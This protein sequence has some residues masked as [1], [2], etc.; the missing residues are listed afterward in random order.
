M[1]DRKPLNPSSAGSRRQ[2]KP[3]K[4]RQRVKPVFGA[5]G[6]AR[7]RK[8]AA[9]EQGR[10]RKQQLFQR[11]LAIIGKRALTAKR[12]LSGKRKRRAPKERGV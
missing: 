2:R 9:R 5:A 8:N 11:N 4:Q 6:A 12:S 10:M 7:T 3:K 1:A